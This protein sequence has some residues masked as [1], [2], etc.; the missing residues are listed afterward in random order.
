M[1][2]KPFMRCSLRCTWIPGR[3][4][5]DALHSRWIGLFTTTVSFNIFPA[6]SRLGGSGKTQ[7]QQVFINSATQ[8]AEH[9]ITDSSTLGETSGNELHKLQL[10]SDQGTS[11]ES[12]S[13]KFISNYIISLGVR[14]IKSFFFLNFSFFRKNGT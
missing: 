3:G 9:P 10:L 1:K 2:V 14:G 13:L 7:K 12:L 4:F 5:P 11:P 8:L 6:S